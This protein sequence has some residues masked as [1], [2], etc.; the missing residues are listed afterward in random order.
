MKLLKNLLSGITEYQI[1]LILKQNIFEL[2]MVRNLRTKV[3][4]NSAKLTGLFNNLQ[5]HLIQ[6]KTNDLN[7][8]TVH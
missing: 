1:F 3:L 8:L 6:H 2:T 4:N 5:S 7:A